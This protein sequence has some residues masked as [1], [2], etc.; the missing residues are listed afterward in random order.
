MLL[1]CLRVGWNIS[2]NSCPTESNL[3]PS[4]LDLGS[5]LWTKCS[6][7]K[8]SGT[9]GLRS[10]WLRSS[11]LRSFSARSTGFQPATADA[12]PSQ[13]RRD[14]F[15]LLAPLCV[16]FYDFWEP[17]SSQPL[18]I[19]WN[20]WVCNEKLAGESPPETGATGRRPPRQIAMCV[21][22][23]RDVLCEDQRTQKW[24]IKTF[25]FLFF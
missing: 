15:L 6:S 21:C 11:W 19:L 7:Q 12:M 9:T 24:E 17:P 18:V 4:V 1:K 8:C 25:Y 16:C 10:S 5:T 13:I 20:C 2:N 23:P 3:R 22:F 14:T